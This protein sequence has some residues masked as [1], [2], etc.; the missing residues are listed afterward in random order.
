MDLKQTD[1][2]KAYGVTFNELK[3]GHTADWLL[4]YRGGAF[5]LDY[6]DQLALTCRIKDVAFDIVKGSEIVEIY[7]LVQSEDQNMEVVRLEKAPEIAVFVPEGYLPWDDA[8]SLALDYAEVPYSK[9]W[10]KEI[11]RGD[12]SKY[13]WLHLHHEDFTG[14]Y[15][16][17]YASFRN[18]QW[19]VEQQLLYEREAEILGF[20]KVSEME[21]AVVVNIRDYI[22]EGGFLF[23]MCSAADSYDIALSA[24]SVDIADRMYDGDPP[25]PDAQEK[26]NFENTLAFENFKLEMNPMVY[27][28]SDI[29]IQPQEIGNQNND[30]FSLFDYSAK[31]DP[32]P[33]MLI[34]NHVN[35]IRGF[36]G[37]TTMFRKELLKKS[38]YVLAERAGTNQVK[39]I[40]GNFGRGT[41][42]FYGGHDPED[43]T[44]AVG[45]PPT[46][47]SLFKNS[48]G[49]RLILNNIL[50]PAAKKK[51][52]KT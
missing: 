31:Y 22:A 45:D 37:Q 26:L 33:T 15:G 11:L 46:D 8:V 1:H 48:P 49:Y 40:H 12:L 42:T 28:Y 5:M 39:Y 6:T 3:K 29:D 4:N 20:S 2:L 9:I 14:Q 30:Y 21:K 23:A 25:D 52:Q 47:L 10:L 34:Q 51:K 44:H 32:V 13:D 19:Y 7:S 35:V 36:M 50:F 27:E 17:F 18:A 41:F 38:V 24:L 43:Y 16:K